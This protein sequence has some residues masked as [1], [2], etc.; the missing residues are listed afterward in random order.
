MFSTLSMIFSE[1]FLFVLIS[2]HQQLSAN[3]KCCKWTLWLGL[4]DI[5]CFLRETFPD[6]PIKK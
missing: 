4:G 6:H 5:H 2:A 3:A 1:L